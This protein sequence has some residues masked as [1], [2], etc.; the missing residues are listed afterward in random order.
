MS[1]NKGKTGEEWRPVVINDGAWSG[2]YEVSSWGRVRSA[3]LAPRSGGRK[4]GRALF[5]S[6]DS[7][8]Y[9]QVTLYRH[10]KGTTVK[11]HRLV[12]TA[13]M[14]KPFDAAQVNHRD[15]IKTNNAIDNLEYVSNKENQEH[16]AKTLRDSWIVRGEPMAVPEAVRRF[17]SPGVHVGMVRRRVNRLG[18]SIDRAL[19]TPP[20]PS[21][22]PHDGGTAWAR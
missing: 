6:L 7:K 16:A 3:P 17:A 22:R 13:F 4:P 19:S 1:R 2:V 5:M 8:G 10:G 20:L 9:P 11:V 14:T 21:G 18:W 15:G 12:A